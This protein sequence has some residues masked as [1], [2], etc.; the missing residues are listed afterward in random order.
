MS[1]R[2]KGAATH[3]DDDLF[4]LD[5][6]LED[7]MFAAHFADAQA[8]SEL[9]ATL[10]AARKSG[11]MTQK[12]VAAAMQTTQSTVSQFESGANDPHLS[13][14]QRYARAVG[15]RVVVRVDLPNRGIATEDPWA[16]DVRHDRYGV[17]KTKT[18]RA[19]RA[20]Q[21]AGTEHWMRSLDQ[22]SA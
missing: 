11:G 8:R 3:P 13:T 18:A 14:L 5:S 1:N 6:Y 10:L 19:T 2:P 4:D 7:P 9:R 21:P 17:R 15:A 20:A 16:R 12:D 22:R